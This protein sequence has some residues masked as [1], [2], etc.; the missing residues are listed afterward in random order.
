MLAKRLDD[1]ICEIRQEVQTCQA[2]LTEGV[3]HALKAGALLLEAKTL[4]P[5]GGWLPFVEKCGLTPRTAQG[6]M[7]VARRWSEIESKYETVSHLSFHKALA[8]LAQT[9]VPA[10]RRI[11]DDLSNEGERVEVAHEAVARFQAAVEWGMMEMNVARSNPWDGSLPDPALDQMRIE[12]GWEPEY[13][14]KILDHLESM[15]RVER[16]SEREWVNRGKTYRFPG[17]R[18]IGGNPPK[19]L[20]WSFGDGSQEGASMTE[21]EG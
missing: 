8:L 15:G 7:R 18:W 17:W 2:S 9:K 12:M 21:T 10:C 11:E 16:L 4:I 20:W 19:G 3:T 6:Y 13:L 1:L 5:H 14:E